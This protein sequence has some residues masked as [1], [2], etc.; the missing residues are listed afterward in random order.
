MVKFRIFEKL[1]KPSTSG[2]TK[3]KSSKDSISQ[4][5]E[6]GSGADTNPASGHSNE[7]SLFRILNDEFSCNCCLELLKRPVTL[8]CGHSFCQL[9]LANWYLASLNS[10]CPSC[11]QEWKSMPKVNSK[12][13]SSI[14]KLARYELT[15][16]STSSRSGEN[17]QDYLTNLNKLNKDEKK[18]LK[19]FEDKFRSKTNG[20]YLFR[21]L[22]DFNMNYDLTGSAT[23]DVTDNENDDTTE[24][25]ADFPGSN[26]LSEAGVPDG[27]LRRGQTDGV[28]YSVRNL[29]DSLAQF[30]RGMN[31][32][33]PVIVYGF[34]F[35][36]LTV[37]PLLIVFWLLSS[38]LSSKVSLGS[39]IGQLRYKYNRPLE[40]WTQ[41]ET[42]E[43]FYQLGPWTTELASIAQINNYGI[44]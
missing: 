6:D 34:I 33:I 18:S 29:I 8:A 20:F 5:A 9:C 28:E 31:P 4:L 17:L 19:K 42:Q 25:F 44:Y 36:L 15:Q 3:S 2:L 38:S 16:P 22:S 40:T 26:L 37:I 12:L 39:S 1:L 11:R 23:T 24:E 43:W 10:T 7:Q 41:S 14:E 27:Y 32:Y 30:V 35:G 13:K 21:N